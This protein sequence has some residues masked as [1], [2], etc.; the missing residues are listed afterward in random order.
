MIIENK[1]TE[2]GDVLRISTDVPVLGLVLLSGFM[3]DTDGETGDVYFIKKFRYSKDIGVTWSEW[4]DLNQGN[5]QAVP[6]S[7]KESFLF[8]YAYQQEGENGELYFN[9]VQLEGEVNQGDDVIYSKTDFKQFFD[10][11]D[12]NVLGWAFNVLEKLYE[13]G[14]LPKYVQRDYTENSKDFIDYWLSITHF[15]A[16]IVYMAR[17]FQDIPKNKILFDLFLESKGLS[18]SGEE[19]R[20]QREYLFANY[21]DEFRKRGTKNITSTDG[22][23]N[24]EFMR[25]IN[26]KDTDEFLFF[27]LV[28][29]DLGWCCD[30]SSPTWTGTEQIINAMKAYE[31]SVNIDDKSKYPLSGD[32]GN[33]DI[34]K[35]NEGT[36]NETRWLSLP[37]TPGFNG[38]EAPAS[39]DKL[40][41]ISPSLSYEIYFKVKSI[42]G[43]D[44]D[45]DH[46][47]FGANGYNDK[48]EKVDFYNGQTGEAL[49]SFF[50]KDTPLSLKK[51]NTEYWFRGVITRADTVTKPNIHLNFENGVPL[52]SDRSIKYFTPVIGQKYVAGD[53]TIMIRD[54]KVK[55]LDLPI[56]RG[57]LGSIL[58]IVSYF[59]NNSGKERDYIK[60]F[61]EK[62]LLG[63]K[64]NIILPTYLTGIELTTYTLTVEWVPT[65]GGIVT[66]GGTYREGDIAVVR[67]T[68]SVGY[69]VGTVTIDGEQKTISNQYLVSM[70]KNREV[71]VV[72]TQSLMNFVSSARNVSFEGTEYEDDLVIDWG[73]GITTKNQLAHPYSDTLSTHVITINKGNVTVLKG[74]GNKISVV[75]IINMPDMAT[76]DLSNNELATIDLSSLS[77]LTLLNLEKNKLSTISLTA[78]P[79]LTFLNVENNNLVSLSTANLLSLETLRAGKNRLTSLNLSANVN[80]VSLT[81]GENNLSSLNLGMAPKLAYVD[82]NTNKLTA[83]IVPSTN[84]LSFLNISSNSIVDGVFDGSGYPELTT[85]YINSMPSMKTL[86]VTNTPNLLAFHSN[87][88]PVVTDATI[89]GNSFIMAINMQDCPNLVNAD[90]SNNQRTSSVNVKNDVSLKT[91]KTDDT[92]LSSIDLTTN[93]SLMVLSMNNNKFT[94]FSAPYCTKLEKLSMTGNGLTSLTLTNN[95]LLTDITVNDNK[96]T[97][98]DLSVQKSLRN[99]NC[100]SNLLT[101]ISGSTFTSSDYI[102]TILASDNKF[103]EFI[104]TGKNLLK[105]VDISDCSV[106]KTVTITN[107]PVFE[108]LDLSNDVAL[109]TLDGYDNALKTVDISSSVKLRYVHLQN[110]QISS[111][112]YD[113]CKAIANMNL[114][115]NLLT[116]F[117]PNII[118]GSLKGLYI[119]ENQLTTLDFTSTTS[120]QILDCD[121]NALTSLT[122]NPSTDTPTSIDNVVNRLSEAPQLAYALNGNEAKMARS[123][124]AFDTFIAVDDYEDGFIKGTKALK[125]TDSYATFPSEMIGEGVAAVSGS[126]MVYPLD[127]TSYNGLCGGVMF[128][129]NTGQFGWALGWGGNSFSNKLNLDI[130]TAGGRLACQAIQLATNKWQHVMFRLRY[131]GGTSWHVE[132]YVNG[133]KYEKFDTPFGGTGSQTSLSFAG[134]SKAPHNGNFYFGRAYQSG[135]R[136][137]NG[138]VQDVVI[139]DSYFSDDDVN[140]FDTFYKNAGISRFS[141]LTKVDCSYNRLTV[142]DVS[143]ANYITDL[144]CSHNNIGKDTAY[145]QSSL[146][147]DN[148]LDSNKIQ[149]LDA[150]YNQLKYLDFTRNTNLVNVTINDNTALNKIESSTT[151]YAMESVKNMIAFNTGLINL[152]ISTYSGL[153]KLD[154]HDCPGF[155]S[156]I[157]YTY[158]NSLEYLDLSNCVSFKSS[159]FTDM[160]NNVIDNVKE[161]YLKGLTQLNVEL[162]VSKLAGL[163]K[164]DTT[165]SA[166]NTIKTRDTNLGVAAG[167]LEWWSSEGCSNLKAAQLIDVDKLKYLNFASSG[168]T[169]IGV[170]GDESKAYEEIHVEHTPIIKNSLALTYIAFLGSLNQTTVGKIYTSNDDY[171]LKQALYK[172]QVESKGWTIIFVD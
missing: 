57:Y 154:L 157:S 162:N 114:S 38:I 64:N 66:G 101:N 83:F 68:P 93:G 56:E 171:F 2:N 33:I 17:Q 108:N 115:K 145:D 125:M 116:A 18:L 36:V 141:G 54:I 41:K 11:N 91:L 44:S 119:S 37:A 156:F 43:N 129:S 49:N 25:L 40:L 15:F 136:Q 26:Y 60:N 69:Q 92:P 128:G 28:F 29:Q 160:N 133:V 85:L 121:N 120:L 81:A 73:D 161:L 23:V 7:E 152:K 172:D 45:T 47:T 99:L 140:L 72:F 139:T 84:V 150:S 166:F 74:S 22:T 77:K 3:D 142:L 167:S 70:D 10:V 53:K 65:S 30:L 158:V 21:I 168:V 90:Y 32:S 4:Q 71:S 103:T 48:L 55:P 94:E 123:T 126:F 105:T 27:N 88:N 12:I 76:I 20:V 143:K 87:E 151:T 78:T 31:Y 112:N 111:I 8:E 80:L 67:I 149:N 61:T 147:F 13:R 146:I 14:I 39:K 59:Y 117:N 102:T 62:Y 155:T 1:T 79:L 46:V 159:E 107:N 169:S 75:N 89:T 9:W 131:A 51:T 106:L 134:L 110:N 148:T 137:F 63:Y 6:I 135:W 95:T 109:I 97:V 82:V 24:G 35:E 132:L 118:G 164:L 34:V 96:L 138:Y 153:K 165:N 98:L 19:T 50:D 163:Q 100:S 42:S 104:A 5:I 86:K 113:G 58:P 127:N 130:Y 122:F 16:I 144:D 52:I 124:L 170:S